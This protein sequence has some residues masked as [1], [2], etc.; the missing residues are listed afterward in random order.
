MDEIFGRGDQ[1]EWN[2]AVLPEDVEMLL[3]LK[4]EFGEGPF[5]VVMVR[6]V[7]D[8]PD[9]PQTI[10]LQIGGRTLPFSG[11]WFQHVRH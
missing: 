1:V 5:E 2:E 4:K 11:K 9:H 6:T 10:T 8:S 3:R 7:Y